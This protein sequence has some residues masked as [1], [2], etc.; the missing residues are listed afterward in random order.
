MNS[1]QMCAFGHVEAAYDPSIVVLPIWWW[2][3]R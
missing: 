3:N 1:K 2:L